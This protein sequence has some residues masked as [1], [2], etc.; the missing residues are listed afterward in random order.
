M[1]MLKY[2]L[3]RNR[4]LVAVF[5]VALLVRL[6]LI[7]VAPEANLSTYALGAD[8]S[9][10]VNEARNILNGH[11]F[12]R[13]TG[14][15]YLPDAIRTPLYPLFL[16]GVYALFGSFGAVPYMQALLG[17]T[18]PVVGVLLAGLFVRDRRALLAAGALL[19]FE[20]HTLFATTFFASEGLFVPML[21][22]GLYLLVRSVRR[23]DEPQL[24]I[25]ALIL[26]LS[27]LVR[28]ITFYL[29]GLLLVALAYHAYERRIPAKEALRYLAAFTAVFL[30]AVSP[31]LVRNYMHFGMPSMS[32]V[33]WFN[34]Y[35]RLAATSRAIETGEEFYVSYRALLDELSVR[36]YVAHPPPVSE[37]EIQDPRFGEVLK[38]ES[39]RVI[40]EH[41]RGF[42]L[43]AASVPVSVLTQDNTLGIIE[44]MTGYRPARP[45]FSPTLYL[46]QH[47]LRE[48]L[49]AVAPYL[50]GPY[51]VPYLM[52]LVWGALFVFAF[53][54]AV[55]L[56]M[57]KERFAALFLF[58]FIP[59]VILFSLNAGAQIDGRYR[60]QIIV[61]EAALAA[62]ALERLRNRAESP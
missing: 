54:G 27:A 39:L 61:V 23:R 34:V 43:F 2:F 30:L 17:S 19:V 57:R 29:P 36:G 5:L 16:A 26:G 40:A 15:P 51:I 10:Y 12:S 8:G 62:V 49:A 56:W 25:A 24:L 44:W 32:T 52:R 46:S 47:G 9:D 59:F 7:M 11:G 31:W 14:E 4:L 35:T 21:V 60:T 6:A 22:L 28:P 53:A 41:P 38:K 42:I 3:S 48:T 55:I 50:A 58:G 37:L 33:G 18:V 1:I 45:S 13:S 20:P